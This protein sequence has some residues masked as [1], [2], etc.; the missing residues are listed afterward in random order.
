[1]NWLK[2]FISKRLLSLFGAP[3][4]LFLLAKVN[5]MTGNVLTEQ[6][7][8]SIIEW[9]LGALVLYIGGQTVVEG[10]KANG[11]TSVAKAD[12]TNPATPAPDYSFMDRI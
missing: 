12:A 4:L 11:I 9:I 7:I 3:I 6:Q 8:S 1:M 10:V 2:K 5:T